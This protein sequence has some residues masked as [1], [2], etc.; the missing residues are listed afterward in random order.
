MNSGEVKIYDDLGRVVI[1][2]AVTVSENKI[3]TVSLTSGTY[4]VVLRTEYGNAT[5]NLVID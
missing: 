4:I 3:E 1:K 5:K 2:Q